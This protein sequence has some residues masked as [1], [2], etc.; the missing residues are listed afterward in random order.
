MTGVFLQVWSAYASNYY[1]PFFH[2]VDW[3]AVR[4][5]YRPARGGMPDAGRN[6]TT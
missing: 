1:D 2:G 4:E 3:T 6:S 5:K